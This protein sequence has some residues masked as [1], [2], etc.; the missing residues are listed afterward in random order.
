MRIYIS[1]SFSTRFLFFIFCWRNI[2][3]VDGKYEILV[4][5]YVIV[6]FYNVKIYP[7]IHFHFKIVV[8][9]IMKEIVV[10]QF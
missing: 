5:F 9:I 7:I 2:F 10:I 1:F 4:E 8:I 6:H 3:D